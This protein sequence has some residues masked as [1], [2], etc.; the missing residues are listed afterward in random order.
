[1]VVLKKVLADIAKETM[2][3]VGEKAWEDWALFFFG[4]AMT[5]QPFPDGN[6]RACRAA[7]AI[8]MASAG[9]DFRAPTDK[10]G[11]QLGAMM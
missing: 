4:A 1:M 5:A 11:S 7:Y 10:F 3:K 6:K 8:I 2:P 9:I